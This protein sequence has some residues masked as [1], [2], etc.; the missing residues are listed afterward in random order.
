MFSFVMALL[1]FNSKLRRTLWYA[2]VIFGI[3]DCDV[4]YDVSDLAQIIQNYQNVEMYNQIDQNVK[5][6]DIS[7]WYF[8][9][10]VIIMHMKIH[11]FLIILIYIK[12]YIYL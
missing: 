5:L 7:N 8:D 6:F 3:L 9:I 1:N 2:I 10:Y 4:P 11:I 12:I